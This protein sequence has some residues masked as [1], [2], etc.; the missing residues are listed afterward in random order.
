MNHNI[1]KHFK[2]E[3]IKIIL[4]SLFL[5]SVGLYYSGWHFVSNINEGISAGVVGGQLLNMSH[6]DYHAQFYR[7]SLFFENLSRGY[8][9][10][11]NGYI[12]ASN[13]YTEGL[14]YFPFSAIVGILSFVLGPILSYNLLA[15]FSYVFVGLAGYLMVKQLTKSTA[16]GLVAGV[17]LATVPFRTS[18]LYGQMVYGVDAVL[19]PLLIYF[20]ERA[21][22]LQQRKYFFLAGLILFFTITSNFQFFYWTIFLMSPYLIISLCEYFKSS[23]INLNLNLKIK[24]LA[25]ILPGLLG[26]LAYGIF[27]YTIIKGSGLKS[28][29]NFEETL[30]YTPE[31]Y[32][33]FITFNGNEKNIYLGVTALFV[34]P[35][36]LSPIVRYKKSKTESYYI[37][38]FFLTFIMGILLI[39]GPRIDQSL[40]LNIF[41]W[42]FE[43]IPGF[44]GTRTPGR[45]MAVVTVV[46]AILLGYAVSA[47][48][49][50]YKNKITRYFSSLIAGLLAITIVWDFN[51]PQPNIATFEK[52][53]KAY[54]FIAGKQIKIITLPFNEHPAHYHNTLFLTYALK[55]NL[56]LL[57]GHSSFYPTESVNQFE[58]LFTLNNGFVSYEQWRWLKENNYQYITAHATKNEPNVSPATIANFNISPYV[59]YVMNDKNVYLYKIR[60]DLELS[61]QNDSK[62]INFKAWAESIVKI[63]NEIDQKNNGIRYQHGWY[64][65]EAYLNQRPYRWMKGTESILVLEPHEANWS[66]LSFDYLCPFRDKLNI[67]THPSGAMI[68]FEKEN[69]DEWKNINVKLN[70]VQKQ[71]SFIVL[72]ASKI[73]ESP[74]DT[75]KF[76]CMVSDVVLK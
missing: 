64:G 26:C 73:F 1:I 38:L 5:L 7:Y 25:W 40:K 31:F 30:F 51:Y 76:G 36:L 50:S 42:M 72:S 34:V 18:F 35:W 19:L 12:F 14:I 58:K 44:N 59:E 8:L 41:Q 63:S 55:Y 9:P 75:R 61:M 16:A 47:F 24:I 70:A 45:I 27:I 54:D 68:I 49:E 22:N 32:R 67:S 60:N 62:E 3:K 56:R 74:P 11:Y 6:G 15:L 52:E 37:P 10:Y 28:G 17:Y 33:L 2:S 21:K 23:Q 39:F 69:H 71:A 46:Y 20:V 53:N 48:L 57:N 65:R 4:F 29:Q 13:N 43:N 66:E